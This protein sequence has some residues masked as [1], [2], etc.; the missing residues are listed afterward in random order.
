MTDRN[1][2]QYNHWLHLFHPVFCG[3]DQ[4]FTVYCILYCKL[5]VKSSEGTWEAYCWHLRWWCWPAPLLSTDPLQ[6]LHLLQSPAIGSIFLW[7][8]KNNISKVK[9]CRKRTFVWTTRDNSPSGLRDQLSPYHQHHHRHYH[10]HGHLH[11]QHF[12]DLK[13]VRGGWR[14]T[15]IWVET[16]SSAHRD[17]SSLRTNV[18]FE[19]L[20]PVALLPTLH[21][22]DHKLVSGASLDSVN[23][24][25]VWT[26]A[27]PVTGFH[28]NSRKAYYHWL[29]F[30][31]L[32]LSSQWRQFF[33]IYNLARY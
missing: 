5:C 24:V 10:Q 21:A 7:F 22:P 6:N 8:P 2:F 27:V 28:L 3:L 14:L 19:I 33:K 11:C 15:Q 26:R 29:C 23:Q 12:H 4:L 20:R 18:W 30:H 17:H 1:I 31:I 16:C 13:K 9:K 32:C 25:V